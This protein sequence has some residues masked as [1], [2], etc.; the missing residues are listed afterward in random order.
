MIEKARF[1]YSLLGK[2]FEKQ[3]EAI[4]DHVK[5]LVKS[6]SEE[7]SLS[8]LKHKE[9]FRELADERINEIQNFSKW[10]GFNNLVYYFK[11]E[12]GQKN[13]FRLKYPLVFYKT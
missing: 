13:L 10:I 11:G 9:I 8:L 3:I 7:E 5:Q 12:I 4:E 2:A 1:T 6:S